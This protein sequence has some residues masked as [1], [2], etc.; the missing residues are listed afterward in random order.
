MLDQLHR[1]CAGS[2]LDAA[3]AEAAMNSI[4]AGEATT[5]Q[6]AAFLVAL[7]MKGE[8]AA[9]LVG[10]ARAMRGRANRVETGIST[11]VDTCGTGGDSLGTIN[12]STIAALVV[13]GAGVAV[14]KHGNR[15]ISGRFGS[16]DLMEALG[17]RITM[18]LADAARAIRQAGVGFL[19]APHIHPAMKHAQA[20]RTELKMRTAFNLLGPLTNPAGA[21]FQVTGAPS[22]PAAA[23]MAEALHQLGA[24][25]FV[26][27]GEDG[28]DEITTTAET[29]IW[30][31]GGPRFTVAPEDFG[32]A[33]A[34]IPDLQGDPVAT[35]RAVLGG[36][37]GP[38]RDIVL[39]NAA[40]ALVAAGQSASWREGV[41]RAE[42]SL[43]SGAAQ[44]ALDRLRAV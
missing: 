26:V 37:R 32:V 31:I 9:E 23:L 28:M 2:S 10:L 22:V 7:K 35:A 27:H 15:S 3:E 43:D 1:L 29:H 16:A 25:G 5:A 44:E 41:Q 4:L 12:V 24:R 18:P 38:A 20:A 6:I 13:A 17:V 19:Y 34:S 33:R 21:Q 11:L 42:H 8:T 14:A 36:E 40:A 30:T 39:V